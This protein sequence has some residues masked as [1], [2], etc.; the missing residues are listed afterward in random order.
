MRTDF[1]PPQVFDIIFYFNGWYGDL[2]KHH[3]KCP[4]PKCYMTFWD[5]TIY[6]DSLHSSDISPHLD[7]VIELYLIADFDLITRFREVFMK[8]LQWVR[9]ANRGRL[10]LRTPSPVP[11]WICICSNA[12]TALSLICYVSGLWISNIPRYFYFAYQRATILITPSFYIF[13]LL[14]EVSS[15]S[16]AMFHRNQ[17]APAKSD[18]DR[19]RNGQT[20]RQTVS[21]VKL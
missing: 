7:L 12:E 14:P 16:K 4:S 17:V 18:R 6:S 11:F 3:K 10:L 19:R 21:G 5:M 9:L 1:Q 15:I 20:N 2:I 8:H 13:S